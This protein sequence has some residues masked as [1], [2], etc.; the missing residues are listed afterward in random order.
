MVLV[1]SAM[2]GH[3]CDPFCF[4]E[5][6]GNI[7]EENIDIPSF[8]E[9]GFSGEGRLYFKQ[10]D[11]L[12]LRVVTDDNLL[13]YLRIERS[14]SRLILGIKRGCQLRRYSRLDYYLTGPSLGSLSLS[15]SGNFITENVIETND[16]EISVSGSGKISAM[17]I[18][19]MVESRVSGSGDIKLKGSTGYHEMSV[20]G[21]GDIWAEEFITGNAT[22][23]ISGSGKARLNVTEKLRARVSGS[24]SVTYI[25]NPQV[26]STVSGSGYVS[27]EK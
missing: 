10:D 7:V 15:G 16:L 21:S 6:S 20:S 19:E 3:G 12:S 18:A 26:D 17:I 27:K 2:F 5:G 24:G 11:E 8:S 14:G 4:V 23:S 22:V 9:I 1:M 13:D 25:G